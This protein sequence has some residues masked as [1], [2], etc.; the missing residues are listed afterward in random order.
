MYIKDIT[1]NSRINSLKAVVKELSPIKKFQRMGDPGKLLMVVLEDETG[2]ANL[3]L[4]DDQVD[5]VKKGDEVL[6]ENCKVKEYRGELQI[7]ISNGSI[8]VIK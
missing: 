4:W 1:R 3:A 6:L 7:S 2:I 5:T 8:K